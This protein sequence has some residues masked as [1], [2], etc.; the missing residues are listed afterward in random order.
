MNKRS[1]TFVV[2]SIM[3]SIYIRTTEA[4][5]NNP[6]VFT[7][8]EETTRWI[9]ENTGSNVSIGG[10]VSATDPEFN[11]LMYTLGGPDASSFSIVSTLGW[12]ETKDAL[13]YETKDTYSVTVSVSDGNGGTDSIA[14]TIRVT[15]ANDAPEFSAGSTITL[16]IPENTAAGVGIGNVLSATDQDRDTLTYSLSG[17]DTASFSIVSTTGQLRTSVPL[18]Y[19][20]K[21]TYSVTVNVSDNKGGTDSIAVTINITDVNEAPAFNDGSS[22]TRSIRREYGSRHRHWQRRISDG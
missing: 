16:S 9:A 18:N 17:T 3:L 1:I 10:A 4:Q 6:P 11:E 22:T 5:G 15:D 21:D 19:E 12:L 8:G 7:E 2:V 13:D 20:T 14:V